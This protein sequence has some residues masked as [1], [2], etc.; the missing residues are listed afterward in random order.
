MDKKNLPTIIIV[1]VI[2]AFAFYVFSADTIFAKP[3]EKY[4]TEFLTVLSTAY[5]P[6][7]T[8]ALIGA[9]NVKKEEVSEVKFT[10]IDDK[11]DPA[12]YFKTVVESGPNLIGGVGFTLQDYM[13]DSALENPD[14]NYITVDMT[15]DEAAIPDNL[16]N[17]V[18]RS[19]E[20]SYVAGY[21]AG[22]TSE[23]NIIGFVGGM[24]TSIIRGFYYGFASGIARAE[25]DKGQKITILCEFV[26][27]YDDPYTGMDLAEEMYDAN[28]DII[29]AVAGASGNGVISTAADR[30]EYVIG[31]DSDQNYLAPENVIFSVVKHVDTAVYDMINSYSETG[32]HLSGTIS[33]GYTEGGVGVVSYLEDVISYDVITEAGVIEDN[34]MNGRLAVPNT[35]E[36]YN[37]YISQL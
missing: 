32:E 26:G 14:I 16:A 24:D 33:V 8:L 13:F 7:N 4:K 12:D 2:I 36:E 28:A 37:A 29:Y 17:I 22:M 11:E 15:Y 19:N 5:D 27:S 31:V 18:F 3:E 20:A 10:L 9:F 25:K 30:N 34:I 21:V 23:T 1:V 6:F 35:E